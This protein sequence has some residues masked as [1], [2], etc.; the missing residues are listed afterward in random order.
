MTAKTSGRQDVPRGGDGKFVSNPDAV[1]RDAQACRLRRD[2]YTYE[3]IAS[4]LGYA[5]RG[6][7]YNGVQRALLAIVQEPAEELRT[8]EI[9]RLDYMY[10]KVLEVLHR[11]HFTV[12][13][14]KIVTLYGQPLPDDSP[15]L[16]AVD[17]L[18]RIQER[19]AKLLGLDAPK[20]IEIITLDAIQAEI[21]RLEESMAARDRA[22]AET[23]P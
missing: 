13:N 4:E 15:V 14:G 6:E 21:R 3:Q 16:A 8:L 11:Q 1:A 23:Q 17:R 9:E 10:F 7:A 20:Q 19:R 18:L 22:V 5:G 12:Q 2:G